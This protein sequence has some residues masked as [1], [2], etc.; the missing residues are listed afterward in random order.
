[1]D[2]VFEPSA[3]TGVASGADAFDCAGSAVLN[4]AQKPRTRQTFRT[5]LKSEKGFENRRAK[6][7]SR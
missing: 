5:D 7:T 4:V 2:A 1:M 3:F 6:L